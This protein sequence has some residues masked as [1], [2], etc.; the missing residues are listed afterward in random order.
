MADTRINWIPRW[1]ATLV[2]TLRHSQHA[3]SHIAKKWHAMRPSEPKSA[4]DEKNKT[5]SQTYLAES[6]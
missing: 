1:K 3:T 4:G 5:P 6:R 2:Q